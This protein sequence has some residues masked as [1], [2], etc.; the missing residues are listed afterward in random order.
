MPKPHPSGAGSYTHARSTQRGR[1]PL[2]LA[3]S[4]VALLVG[5]GPTWAESPRPAAG[6]STANGFE[7][8]R[9]SRSAED[10]PYRS[11]SGSPGLSLEAVGLVRTGSEGGLADPFYV[12]T[13]GIFRLGPVLL[14]LGAVIGDEVLFNVHLDV[15]S[16]QSNGWDFSIGAGWVDGGTLRFGVPIIEGLRAR[17]MIS[18]G[19]LG[20][21]G[22]L[23]VEVE[24]W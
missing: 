13:M 5:S 12:R 19:P 20:F 17:A 22:G 23:G 2:C 21:S 18:G 3:L 1:V 7:L 4:T 6:D 9:V 24:P 11:F 10:T 14:S 15:F 8:P 16:Y